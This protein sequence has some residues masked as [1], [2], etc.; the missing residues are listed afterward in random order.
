MEKRIVSWLLLTALLLGVLTLAFDIQPART[1]S[2]TIIVPDDYATIQWAI[3]HASDG[4]T[5]F[6]RS[7]TYYEHVIV[8][9]E[10]SL[11][12]ENKYNTII[13]GNCDGIVVTVTADN[14]KITGFAIQ[15]SGPHVVVGKDGIHIRSSSNNISHNIITHNRDGIYLCSSFNNTISENNIVANFD[16]GIYLQWNSSSNFLS[17]NN[18]T[19]SSCGVF[20]EYGCQYNTI[21]GNNIN[22]CTDGI[23]LDSSNYNGIFGNNVRANRNHGIAIYFSS[24]NSLYENNI[25]NNEN[26]MLILESGELHLCRNNTISRNNIM[27]N[28]YRGIQISSSYN[29]ISGN[30]IKSNGQGIYLGMYSPYNSISGNNITDNGQGIHF[31]ISSNNTIYHCNFVGN[32]EQVYS[33]R[34]TNVWD[35]GYPSGGNYWSDYTGKDRKSGPDQHKG[36]SD[37]I[38]DTPY[39]IDENNQD[40]YSLMNPY[41]AGDVDYD[42]YV[43]SADAGILNGAYGTW[44]GDPLYVQRADFDQDG[45]IGS[46][47]AGILN[48][49][50]GKTAS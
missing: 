1:E 12:G 8:N 38:G 4:D 20:L 10:V 5:I 25:T 44:E 30:K 32:S 22:N 29:S 28:N 17:K 40:N 39:I 16:N 35:D 31:Y 37:G 6:V 27:A 18:I 46:A 47:D 34:S 2:T 15:K 42:G 41:I 26:G 11:V 24:N 45:Y 13:D 48:G 14:V 50:Y 19:D 36:G 23:R 7:G 3:D 21:S 43:G 49:N 9:K 33:D